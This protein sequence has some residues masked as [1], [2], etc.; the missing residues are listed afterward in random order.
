MTTSICLLFL[1]GLAA[2]ITPQN[3]DKRGSKPHTMGNPHKASPAKANAHHAA[4]KDSKKVMSLLEKEQEAKKDKD[5]AGHLQFR[6]KK[7]QG[8][9][10]TSISKL[11]HWLQQ[12]GVADPPKGLFLVLAAVMATIFFAAVASSMRGRVEDKLK[13]IIGAS[14]VSTS[15][16]DVT[17]SETGSTDKELKNRMERFEQRLGEHK[18]RIEDDNSDASSTTSKIRA[19]RMIQ[20]K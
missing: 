8:S 2:A 15:S 13:G 14:G 3:E 9:S 12:I 18:K 1:V 17:S 7:I 4:N 16:S 6:S 11:K 5:E 20:K 19:A 10:G